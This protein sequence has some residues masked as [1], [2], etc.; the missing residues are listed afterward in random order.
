VGGEPAPQPDDPGNPTVDFNDK[1]T[2]IKTH[3]ST[4]DPDALPARKENGKEAKLSCSGHGLMGNRS[5]PAADVEVRQ[6]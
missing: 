1:A 6:A 3:E 5:G 2:A 4:T